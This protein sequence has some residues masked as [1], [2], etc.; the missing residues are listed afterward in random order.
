MFCITPMVV[1][2]IIECIPLY[3]NIV[4]VFYSVVVCVDFLDTYMMS[5]ILFFRKP[6][7]TKSQTIYK[8]T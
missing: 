4:L 6:G 7:V 3:I 2:V 5:L 1:S 8:L